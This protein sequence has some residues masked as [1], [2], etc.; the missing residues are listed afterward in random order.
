MAVP[1]DKKA[2]QGVAQQF[3]ETYERLAL[4][5]GYKTR[6]ASAVPW[7]EVPLTNRLLMISVVEE[8]ME[9][10]VIKIHN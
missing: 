4:H 1:V 2:A 8:L 5:F 3:H 6:E 7:D 9:R 10:G